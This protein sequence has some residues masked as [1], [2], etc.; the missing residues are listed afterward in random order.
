MCSW[1]RFLVDSS[2]FPSRASK[3]MTKWFQEGGVLQ[4]NCVGGKSVNGE[5][6]CVH[7][8]DGTAGPLLTPVVPTHTFFALVNDL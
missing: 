3:N 6:V 4:D 2:T 7:N 8:S 5:G 1:L